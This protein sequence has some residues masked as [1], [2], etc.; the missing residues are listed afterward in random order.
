MIHVGA[1]EATT[2]EAGNIEYWYCQTC[3]N[4]WT[5][6]ACTEIATWE[7]VVLPM[8]DAPDTTDTQN[9][10][11]ATDAS[12]D[13]ENGLPVLVIVLIPV[14]IVGAIVAVVVVLLKKK[15]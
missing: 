14:L 2:E 5:D 1:K 8:L 6:E 3:Q 13:S 11:D 4:V 15:K 9:A 10:T 7:G 12:K